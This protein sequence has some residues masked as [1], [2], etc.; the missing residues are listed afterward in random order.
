MLKY[1]NIHYISDDYNSSNAVHLKDLILGN[2]EY[3]FKDFE[4]LTSLKLYR[5]YD[6]DMIDT[7]RW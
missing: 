5:N 1:L 7:N 6:I 2:F 3:K 4:K